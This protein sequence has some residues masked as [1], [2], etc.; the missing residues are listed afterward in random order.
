M[1]RKTKKIAA[2][3]RCQASAWRV[4][5]SAVKS[6]SPIEAAPTIRTQST[7]STGSPES[8]RPVVSPRMK[9]GSSRKGSPPRKAQR[10]C[11]AQMRLAEFTGGDCTRNGW[12]RGRDE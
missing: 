2:M 4:S 10:S 6:E 1:V 3:T 8:G 9:R 5:P 12:P 7:S 11:S